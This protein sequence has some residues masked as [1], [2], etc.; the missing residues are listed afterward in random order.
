MSNLLLYGKQYQS[1]VSHLAL[2]IGGRMLK[3]KK[4]T[5][6]IQKTNQKSKVIFNLLSS[7][8]KVAVGKSGDGKLDFEK[9]NVARA[10]LVEDQYDKFLENLRQVE[11][12]YKP[13]DPEKQGEEAE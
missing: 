11:K 4:E 5:E 8:L 7:A 1:E 10:Y 13:F 12:D 3:D 2:A 6:S 9:M